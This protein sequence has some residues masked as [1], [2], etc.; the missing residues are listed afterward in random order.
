MNAAKREL[1]FR[2]LFEATSA[3]KRFLLGIASLVAAS[4]VIIGA[5]KVG[6]RAND[7]HTRKLIKEQ[8]APIENMLRFGMDHYGLWEDYQRWQ[9]NQKSHEEIFQGESAG[10]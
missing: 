9:D 3:F 7:A 1:S 8:T 6:A 10:K 4:G 5:L 2:E